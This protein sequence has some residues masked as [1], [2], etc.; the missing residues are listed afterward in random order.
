MFKNE[1]L[2]SKGINWND[3]NFYS[4]NKEQLIV[5]VNCYRIFCY[6]QNLK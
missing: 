2:I 4:L 3:L 6:F 5:Y 1:Y